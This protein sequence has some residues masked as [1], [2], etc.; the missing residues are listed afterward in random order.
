MR[1][2]VFFLFVSWALPAVAWD[3]TPCWGDSSYLKAGYY[4]TCAAF[5]PQFFLK[6]RYNTRDQIRKDMNEPG[7]SF[8]DGGM[9]Y[10][11]NYGRGRLGF[12]GDVDFSFDDAGRVIIISADIGD[13]IRLGVS[14]QYTWNAQYNFFCSDVPG[15]T[16]QCTG[17]NAVPLPKISAQ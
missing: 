4:I 5:T 13:P 10:L 9:R 14:D 8:S 6:L 17:P 3:N 15:S 1:F 12:D 2:F 11:S 16:S 7:K